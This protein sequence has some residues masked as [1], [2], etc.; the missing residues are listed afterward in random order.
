MLFPVGAVVGVF[1]GVLFVVKVYVGVRVLVKVAV[2]PLVGVSAG[3]PP[4][5]S[6]VLDQTGLEFP[7]T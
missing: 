3:T 1:V 6:K 7:L 4:D 5:L 2:G